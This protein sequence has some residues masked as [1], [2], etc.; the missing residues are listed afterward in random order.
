MGKALIKYPET[1]VTRLRMHNKT[2]DVRRDNFK[3][4][5]PVRQSGGRLKQHVL[6][7]LFFWTMF[8]G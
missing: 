7:R 6:R 2:M 8:A 5:M 3:S 1:E 4:I